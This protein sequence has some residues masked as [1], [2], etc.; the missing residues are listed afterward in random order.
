[1][2]DKLNIFYIFLL[3]TKQI[4]SLQLINERNESFLYKLVLVV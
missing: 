4:L 2:L 1:M 3:F